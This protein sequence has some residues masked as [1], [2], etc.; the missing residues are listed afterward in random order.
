MKVTSVDVLSCEGG[1]RILNFVKIQTDEGLTGVCR[2]QLRAIG[3]DP[4]RS[5]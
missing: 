4:G 5:D 2:V 1:W 3:A